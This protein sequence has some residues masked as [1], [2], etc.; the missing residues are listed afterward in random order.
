MLTAIVVTVSILTLA[1]I[2]GKNQKLN[3]NGVLISHIVLATISRK[4]LS[5]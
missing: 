3:K 1:W 5:K 2:V 4:S